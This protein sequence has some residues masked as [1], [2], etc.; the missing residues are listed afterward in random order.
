[1]EVGDCGVDMWGAIFD[2][3]VEHEAESEGALGG[4]GYGVGCGGLLLG[5][6]PN[7]P[8]NARRR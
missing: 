8:W 3:D 4:A 2:G 7:F 1:M 6:P 5:I